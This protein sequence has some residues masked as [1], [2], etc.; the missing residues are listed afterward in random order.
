M[1]A[2]APFQAST[3]ATILR[4]RLAKTTVA[5][6][7][8][9]LAPN[10]G[11]NAAMGRVLVILALLGCKKGLPIEQAILGEWETW[12]YTSKETS[13]CLKK[14]SDGLHKRF[15]EGG[16]LV[17]TRPGEPPTDK[18][19]WRLA[20]D[21][22]F[23][24][25]TG[26]GMMLHEDYFARIEDDRLVLWD[27]QNGRGQVLG[28]V[29]A[30][31]AAGDSPV[32]KGGRVSVTKQGATFTIALPDEYRQTRD[33]AYKQSWAP[34]SG[35]GFEVQLSVTKRAQTEV[36]TK[37]VTPPCNDR[38]YGGISGSSKMVG[39]VERETSIG[40]SICVDGTDLVIMCSTGHTRGYLEPSE[41]D[42][43]LALCKSIQ[44]S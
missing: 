17:V 15:I 14:D 23:I 41:R 19:T 24:E 1:Q 12:C 9:E 31:F 22:L 36:G 3:I 20:K 26:G 42:A 5:T 18:A 25:V 37:F 7:E 13:E 38:D 44:R 30:V 8:V 4:G 11:M 21:H 29:G 39:G 28:R 33:D 2:R 6:K 27:R 16:E 43:A 32:S 34:V 35:D 10:C 40:T